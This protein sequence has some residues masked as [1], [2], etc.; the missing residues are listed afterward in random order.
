[1]H[2]VSDA[3]EFCKYADDTYIFTPAVNVDSRSAELCNITDP[4]RKYNLK[5]NFA[6]SQAIMFVD[7]RREANLTILFSQSVVNT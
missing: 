6:K 4:A 7:R 3:N 1:L 2:A 5:L